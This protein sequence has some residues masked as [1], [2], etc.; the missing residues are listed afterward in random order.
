QFDLSSLGNA[1]ADAALRIRLHRASS[2]ATYDYDTSFGVDLYGSTDNRASTVTEGDAGA[3][4]EHFDTS[5]NQLA[6]PFAYGDED[7]GAWIEAD[8]TSFLQDRWTDYEADPSQSWVFFR[9]QADGQSSGEDFRFYSAD[10]GDSYQ[11]EL[12]VTTVPEP[13]SLALLALGGLALLP[14]R[15]RAN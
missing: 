11:P 4:S 2:S 6:D 12:A 15:R 8:V 5:Y 13:A 9:L 7:D 14:R 3:T 1:V 10:M